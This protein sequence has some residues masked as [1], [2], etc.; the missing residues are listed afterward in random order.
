MEF[1][2][3]ASNC[4]AFN[5]KTHAYALLHNAQKPVLVDA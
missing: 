3:N 5:R 2:L 1:Q 4:R